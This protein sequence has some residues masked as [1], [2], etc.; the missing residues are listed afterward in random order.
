MSEFLVVA[1]ADWTALKVADSGM[2][3]ETIQTASYQT[4]NEML[5]I[6]GM[7]TDLQQVAECR[8]IDGDTFFVR[9]ID[10]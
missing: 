6:V 9:L 5:R 7:I 4:L 1:P 8:V 10:A 2:A 3:M